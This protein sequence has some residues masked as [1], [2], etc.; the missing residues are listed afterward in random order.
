MKKITLLFFIL[1]ASLGFAQPTTNA[2]TPTNDSADVISVYSDAYTDVATNY[3][4]GW[5]Q[6][7]SVNTTY[8]PTGG[9]TNFAMAY[10]NFNYQGTELTTQN[11]SG[12]EFLH[13]DLWTS[14]DPGATTI[15]VSPI[16]NGT[17]TGETLVT[18][19]YTSGTWI[20]VDIPKAIFTG[21]T[22]DSVFQMKF[23]ANG[24]GSTVPVDIYLD[25]VYFWKAPADPNTDATLS[26]L[27]VDGT[28]IS[29]FGSAT[30]DYTYE[31]PNG[32]V[33]VPQITTATP[34]QA[35]LGATA[36]ITQA[37]G[38][39]GDA[40]VLVTAPN[41]TDTETYTVSIVA[42]GPPAAAPTP[43]AR[44]AA[45]VKSLFSDAYT[46][47]VTFGYGGDVDT[48]NT[49]WCGA[50]TELA[51]V[52]GNAVNKVSG[53]GCEGVD[54]QSGRFD[55]TAFTHFHMDIYTDTA[56]L[57]KSFNVKFS[58]WNGGGGEA[59]AIE[60]SGNNGNFLTNP[61]PGTWI[62]LDIPLADFTAIVNADRNDL[63]QFV[64]S[65]DLGTVYYD[66]LYL[67]KNTTLGTDE[68]EVSYFSVYP[69]PSNNVWNVK[70]KDQII[71]TIH[72]FD[73]LGKEVMTMKPNLTDVSIDAS[74]LPKGLYFAKM[75]TD[76]G[77]NSVKLI[78]N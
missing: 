37:S 8:D 63:V 57:D 12:M 27:Q 68:F 48:Y 28:T 14:A 40:T 47:I 23:A 55:A 73:V 76:L 21:M 69:N 51:S 36:S 10:T 16:N 3:N 71:N 60:Y 41:G 20:S 56:T 26:D 39:P 53:L 65:S 77:S 33:I 17:G 50:T 75:T 18:I 59:N 54:F 4:P 24:A 6:S 29:G 44:P 9:G 43:P 32:T 52:D 2:P 45:D 31:V 22:W 5:G 61:N 1:T 19:T 35:G 42:L 66:N 30:T 58:N 72:V 62:S 11:A 64:I 13:V 34:T 38:I 46:D 70:T 78:K 25:N 67:H 49:S 74:T 15:Q 7:G